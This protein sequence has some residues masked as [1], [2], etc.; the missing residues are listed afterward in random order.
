MVQGKEG[1]KGVEAVEVLRVR[2][3]AVDR[4]GVETRDGDSDQK[5]LISSMA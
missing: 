4:S 1:R 2:E 3:D 5:E